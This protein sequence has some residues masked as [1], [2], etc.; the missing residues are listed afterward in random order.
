[1][2]V[3]ANVCDPSGEYREMD[4]ELNCVRLRFAQSIIKVPAIKKLSCSLSLIF[5]FLARSLS[6]CF[7]FSL[8]LSGSLWCF[9]L[10]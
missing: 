2:Y 5:I 3:C 6:F 4:P 7:S 1:M 9:G 8:L 10:K